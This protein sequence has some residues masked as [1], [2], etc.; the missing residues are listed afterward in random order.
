[1]E[2]KLE[3]LLEQ[4]ALL[5]A[6]L[7]GGATLPPQ[8]DTPEVP[9][10]EHRPIL[11][12]LDGVDWLGFVRQWG[13]H[14]SRGDEDRCLKTLISGFGA[15][16]TGVHQ[17]MA[18]SPLCALFEAAS[19]W[20]RSE[21]DAI[22]VRTYVD[23]SCGDGL[24]NWNG[25]FQALYVYLQKEDGEPDVFAGTTFAEFCE[26]LSRAIWTELVVGG[27]LSSIHPENW[28]GSSRS[29]PNL[30]GLFANVSTALGLV[31]YY[32]GEGRGPGEKTLR[33]IQGGSGSGDYG[34]SLPG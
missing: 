30:M 20:C 7:T 12:I 21:A 18:Y 1:M 29:R 15:A 16:L 19:D 13:H 17:S 9:R 10:P 32:L 23:R 33:D 11:E 6:T 34:F 26:A 3:Q 2:E 8:D 24:L 28:E 25:F 22:P 31:A 14:G 5:L 27:G 4:M